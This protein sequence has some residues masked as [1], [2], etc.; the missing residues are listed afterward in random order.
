MRRLHVLVLCGLFGTSCLDAPPSYQAETQIPPFVIAAEVR[1]PIGS[2]SVVQVGEPLRI[3][4][5]FLSDDLGEGPVGYIVVDELASEHAPPPSA[6]PFPLPASTFAD[7]SRRVQE[8]FS[9]PLNSELGCH[10]VT[11][12]LTYGSNI[13]LGAAI[14]ERRTARVVW[15]INLVGL[16]DGSG[17]SASL[18]GCPTTGGPAG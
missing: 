13:S 6:G 15:W 3:D 7:D 11:L 18:D 9:L 10:T 16:S 4:V 5:P 12:V 14:D 17:N 8:E 2:V 1:P